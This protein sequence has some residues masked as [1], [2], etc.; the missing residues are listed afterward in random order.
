VN[1]IESSEVTID[2]GG[3]SNDEA[4]IKVWNVHSVKY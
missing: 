2:S 3:I 1:L 4:Q